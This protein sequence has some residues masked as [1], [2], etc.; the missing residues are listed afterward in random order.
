MNTQKIKKKNI[1]VKF[2]KIIYFMNIQKKI[3]RQWEPKVYGKKDILVNDK[4][5]S[6]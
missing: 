2:D 5:N 6:K 3:R 4:K 1:L